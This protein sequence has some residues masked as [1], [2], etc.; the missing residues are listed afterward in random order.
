MINYLT[1]FQHRAIVSWKTSEISCCLSLSL[2]TQ[3]DKIKILVISKIIFLQKLR[4]PFLDHYLW[5]K[6][7]LDGTMFK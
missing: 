4:T 6:V 1:S 2:S 5:K 3:C 7:F